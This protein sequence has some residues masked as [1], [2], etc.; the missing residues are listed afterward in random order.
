MTLTITVYKISV[1]NYEWLSG[2]G[3]EI[4]FAGEGGTC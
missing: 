3:Y 4:I 2:L 1:E